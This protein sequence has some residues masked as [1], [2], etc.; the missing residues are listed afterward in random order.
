MSSS[1]LY[2]LIIYQRRGCHSVSLYCTGFPRT[3]G[4]KRAEAR[5][6]AFH[7]VVMFDF[8]LSFSGYLMDYF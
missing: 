5:Y 6:P 1:T 2:G 7:F 4:G 3:K 8:N